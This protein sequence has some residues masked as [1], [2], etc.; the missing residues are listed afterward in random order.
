VLGVHREE[1]DHVYPAMYAILAERV[2]QCILAACNH[3]NSRQK[4]EQSTEIEPHSIVRKYGK[5]FSWDVREC[6]IKEAQQINE[7]GT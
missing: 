6:E 3:C 7:A 5:I 1:Q 4:M 2:L